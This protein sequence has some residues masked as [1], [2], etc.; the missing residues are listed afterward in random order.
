MKITWWALT[1]LPFGCTSFL[2]GCGGGN[3]I[4]SS[5]GAPAVSIAF[6]AASVSVNGTIEY[7]AQTSGSGVSEPTWSL[8]TIGD[9]VN[10]GTLSSSTGKSVTYTAPPTPPVYDSAQPID[11]SYQGIVTLQASVQSPFGSAVTSTTTIITA[12]SVTTGITPASATVALG[13]TLYFTGDAV[14]NVNNA[15]TFQ[16]DGVDGGSQGSGTITNV[17]GS[18]GVYTAPAIMPM[19]G[20][21]VTV[22]VVSQADPTKSASATVT[23]H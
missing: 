10:L 18:Q 12:P 19:S 16:V 23:L 14:G 11:P 15:V 22:T 1:L 4:G 9:P 7:S 21:A 3:S 6:H 13:E 17:A 5:M 8:Q 2:C 20:D